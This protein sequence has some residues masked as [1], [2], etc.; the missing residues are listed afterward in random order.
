MKDIELRHLRYFVAVAEELSFTRAAAR[1]A[2]AQPPLSQQILQHERS[3]GH[4]LFVRRPHVSL[5]VAG[6]EFLAGARHVLLLSE[7]AVQSARRAA[8]GEQGIVHVGLASTAVMTA[9][10]AIIRTFS[11]EHPGVAIRLHEMHSAEQIEA[12]QSGVL[13]VGIMRE[14]GTA[15]DL[16]AEEIVR[17][18]L[19]AVMSAKHPL[20]KRRAVATRLLA[21]EPFVLFPPNVAPTLHDQILAVCREAGF[22]PHVEQDAREWHTIVSLVAAG[23]GVSIA[24]AGIAHVRTRG[25]VVR[26]LQPSIPRAVLFLCSRREPGGSAAAAFAKFV[27]ARAR[28]AR[29][30]LHAASTPGAARLPGPP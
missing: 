25:A 23:F 27:I 12:L 9:L 21:G 29:S 11:R 20:A 2:M 15:A 8:T 19:V 17:E 28:A 30:S 6:E 16:V 1:L 13:D 22:T 10:P 5:T 3:V 4:A 18:P 7:R 24:P 14:A 26:P